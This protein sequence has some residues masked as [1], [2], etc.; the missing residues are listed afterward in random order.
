MH[1][2]QI[3]I[4]PLITEKAHWEADVRN[5]YSF[6]VHNNANKHQIRDAVEEIYKVRVTSVECSAKTTR[7]VVC[8]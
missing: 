7:F 6:Q 2:T 5:R 4:K 8:G 1:A 3:I